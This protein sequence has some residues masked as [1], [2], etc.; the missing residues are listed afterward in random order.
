MTATKLQ[1]RNRDGQQI[2]YPIHLDG[3]AQAD[4]DYLTKF[5]QDN[6]NVAPSVSVIIRAALSH[7]RSF[8]M[9]QPAFIKDVEALAEFIQEH[10]DLLFFVAGRSERAS[11][12][13]YFTTS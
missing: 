10:R 6:L 4:L 1:A 7:Y 3:I 13:R 2:R 12:A 5:A 9:A 8:L 11:D